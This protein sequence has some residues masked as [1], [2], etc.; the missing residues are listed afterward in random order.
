M[1]FVKIEDGTMNIEAVVFPELYEKHQQRMQPG[2][3]FVAGL[4]TQTTGQKQSIIVESLE[5]LS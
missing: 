5:E 1:A 2:T 3:M 4:K